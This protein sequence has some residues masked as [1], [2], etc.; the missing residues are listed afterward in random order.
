MR[1]R[2]H[3]AHSEC[4]RPTCS[5]H[6]SRGGGGGGGAR[7]RRPRVQPLCRSGRAWLG[8]TWSGHHPRR[9]SSRRRA[10]GAWPAPPP[11]PTEAVEAAAEA[12][13]A[14]VEEE[15]A[16]CGP[17]E[18]A[19]HGSWD[20]LASL[21][22]RPPPRPPALPRHVSADDLAR[23]ESLALGI[24]RVRTRPQ[25][26]PPPPAAGMALPPDLGVEVSSAGKGGLRLMCCM[27]R[28]VGRTVL[29]AWRSEVG[30]EP[31]TAGRA[32]QAAEEGFTGGQLELR[33]RESQGSKEIADAAGV[34]PVC[35]I[36]GPAPL[37]CP[38]LVQR[39]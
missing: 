29:T 6:A 15:A 13:P 32:G 31:S 10:R 34:S 28:C 39:S 7:H 27:R 2:P 19:M 37:H 16:A 38:S 26:A 3:P 4:C 20:A 9:S 22:E 35:L 1:A 25:L 14:A 11:P 5:H 21:G 12:A 18:R 30:C 23:V 24:P 8:A 17:E 33:C 36:P